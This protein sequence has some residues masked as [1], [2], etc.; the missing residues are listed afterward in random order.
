[1][2]FSPFTLPILTSE[3]ILIISIFI[4]ITVILLL[5]V[6]RTQINWVIKLILIV[7]SS[8]IYVGTYQGMINFTGWPTEQ[9]LPNK[10]QFLF[11][12]HYFRSRSMQPD[13]F[14]CLHIQ[15][16]V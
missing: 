3:I 13:M 1:M 5:I 6:L 4:F 12:L 10:F 16:F 8:L 9:N 11:C 2:V 14:F 7:G 15:S